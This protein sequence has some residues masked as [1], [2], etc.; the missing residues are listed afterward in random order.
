MNMKTIPSAILGILA[1]L[2]VSSATVLTDAQNPTAAAFETMRYGI[3]N[4]VV[5]RLSIDP[6]G[7]K[8]YQSLDEFVD[9]FDVNTWAD[10]IQAMGMEYVIFTAWH[11][12]MCHLGPNDALDRWIASVAIGRTETSATLAVSQ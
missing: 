8:N 11:A 7:Q 3:F 9:G 6:D 12:A 2:A 5:Y 1:S 10:Q 4:H